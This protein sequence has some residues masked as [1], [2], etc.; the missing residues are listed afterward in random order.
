MRRSMAW[1]LFVSLLSA[2]S[3]AGSFATVE[4]VALDESGA[5]LPGATV[6]LTCLAGAR[7]AVTDLRG[8]FVFLGVPA[9]PCTMTAALA[10]FTTTTVPLSPPSGQTL[11]L[12]LV[13]RMGTLAE[14]VTVQAAGPGIMSYSSASLAAVREQRGRFRTESYK[15]IDE[16]PF[17]LVGDHPLSTFSIDVDTASYANVRRFIAGGELPP[18][19]AVRIEELVNYFSFDYPEPP[20]GSPFSV[21]TELG[22][23]PWTA[24]HRLLL[25]GL[26]GRRIEA[27][28]LPARNL[29]FL[30]DV[31]GSMQ[32][33]N[34]LPLLTQ[35]LR[36]LVGQLTAE[37]VVAI[38][39]YAGSEGLVLPPTSGDQK[40]V[41]K[42]A[43]SGLEA[44]GTTNGGA[45]ITLA[46]DLASRSFLKDGVN[47]VILATDGD[48]NVG[49]TDEGSLT[50]LIEAKRESGVYLSVLGFGEGNLKDS[51]MEALADRGNGNYAYID[52]LA[53]AR[54]VLV[55]QAGGTLVTLAR[56]VKIQVEWNPRAVAA[57][58]LIGY[59][60]RRLEDEDFA[61][62]AKDAGEIGASHSVTALY[63]VVPRGV[64][65]PASKVEPLKYQ[66]QRARPEGGREELATVKLRFK[67]PAG[68]RSERLERAVADAPAASLPAATGFAAAVAEF[69]MLLRDS[70]HKGNASFAQVLDL[71]ARFRGTDARG[72]REGFRRL[73]EQAREIAG[74]A[75]AQPVA[76]L[77]N[78]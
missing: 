17:A 3:G 61:D 72:H 71:A 30:I 16:N 68:G 26:Q 18:K 65:V 4:G 34:K 41:I 9:G 51:T 44:G 67:K 57:Y 53:E 70:P 43:L 64:P 48:F 73:V 54:K 28:G 6:T 66:R 10:G 52:S 74:V 38:V 76:L 42:A 24:D 21:T 31:S 23:C 63:E 40:E 56:D 78:R 1:L 2:P 46:Y 11:K 49:V 59:E 77:D 60:N 45:G 35:A 27:A 50:R 37:D 20:A 36:L 33:A 32:P 25:V 19:D 22:P 55:E 12:K 39:V 69:G 13:L 14:E 62:D 15:R 7:T 75:G 47:R 5:V 58:R 29:V 8:A